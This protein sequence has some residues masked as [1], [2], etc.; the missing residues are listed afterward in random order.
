MFPSTVVHV[1][2]VLL[3]I[4]ELMVVLLEPTLESFKPQEGVP[5]SPGLTARVAGRQHSKKHSQ[6][7]FYL[8]KSGIPERKF[9]IAWIPIHRV[10]STD[11]KIRSIWRNLC[12]AFDNLRCI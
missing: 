11:S 9:H 12:D 3:S 1:T 4:G 8:T 6:T 10:V 5:I 2:V 7:Q